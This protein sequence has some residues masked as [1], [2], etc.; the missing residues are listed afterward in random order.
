[1]SRT[2]TCVKDAKTI[3]RKARNAAEQILPKYAQANTSLGGAVD[4]P[5][6][7]SGDAVEAHIFS[8]L[9]VLAHRSNDNDPR[10]D[11]LPGET[12]DGEARRSIVESFG[13][14]AFT[15]NP[16][17]TYQTSP[18]LVFATRGVDGGH[19]EDHECATKSG[20]LPD[21]APWSTAPMIG[22]VSG[23]LAENSRT[24][25]I[26]A[27]P[28][29]QGFPL[30]AIE[31]LRELEANNDRDW[32]KAN[33]ARY[34]ERLIAPVRAL[35]EDLADLGGAHLFRPWN[36]TRFRPGPPI[37]E[38]VGLAI[39]YEGAGGFYVELSLDGLL[40]AAGLHNPAPDQVDRLRRAVDAGRTAAPLTRAI[41]RAQDAG[42]EL[43]GPDL[44]RAPRG[45]PADHPRAE[46]LRRR[47]LTV[48]YRHE[49]GPWLHKPR[50]GA[51]IRDELQA[52]APLV[53]WVREHVG[54]SRP[55]R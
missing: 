35:G 30:D 47:R 11:H 42:L 19:H 14:V 49:I 27:M 6:E 32:F 43:N 41:T 53:Q 37:K 9:R 5:L 28:A 45:Y 20:D 16:D 18:T 26:R 24:S 51:R 36:D 31:F 33:R 25:T 4:V 17:F 29:F 38:H 40:V 3:A 21:Y 34:D 55:T 44:V 12:H 23:A 54:V 1:M 13:R 15:A 39:G 46:L 48:A 2:A 22:T 8:Q 52:A 50:A 7:S 10:A